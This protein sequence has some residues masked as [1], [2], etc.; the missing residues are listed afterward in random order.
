MFKTY[1]HL[2]WEKISH[3]TLSYLRKFKIRMRIVEQEV[4]LQNKDDKW[5]G[6]IIRERI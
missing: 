6:W 3:C 1:E 2:K 5:S 4:K